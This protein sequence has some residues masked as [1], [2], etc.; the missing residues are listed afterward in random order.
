[1]RGANKILAAFI[2]C[3]SLL[4]AVMVASANQQN[5]DDKWKGLEF[6]ELGPAVMGGRIDDFAVVE[7]NP[8]IVFVGTASGGV[9]KT[10]NSGTTWQPV[11]DKQ[12]VS[13]IGAIAIAPSDPSTVWVGTG[14]PN[15]RQSSSWGDGVYKSTDTGKTWKN[16]GLTATRHIG[17]IV[18][19]PRNPDVVYVAALGHLWGPN[20][21]RGVFKSKDGGATWNNVLKINDDTGVSDIAMDPQSPETLYAAAYQRRRTPY[22]F[23]GGGP[24]SVIYKTLDGGATWTKLTKGLPYENGGDTGRI[25]LEIYRADPNIVYA[26][27][28]HEKGGI[29]RSEDKGETWKK[30]GDTNPR[31]SYYSQVRIDPKNDLR[32]WVLGAPMFYSEDGGKTFSTQRVQKIH[33]DFHAMWID[34]SDSNHMIAGSDGGIHWSYDAGR[35]WDF[36]NTIAL[37]QFY[38]MGLDDETPYHICGGLQDNGSWCGPS[39]TLTRD[40]IANEDW[41]LIHG[42][43][44]FYAAIDPV[45]PWIVYTESQDGY[46]SRRD[47]RTGQQR[48]IKPVAKVGEPHYR[49]QWNSPVAVSAHDH[50]TIYYGGNYLFKSTDRGDNW[51][52]LDGDLTTAAD[53][54]KLQIFGRTPD[55]TTL[56]RHD[57]VQEY[58]TITTLSESPLTPNVLWAGTDDGNLQVTRDAGTT[59][60]NVAPKV[61]GLAKGA[62][63]SRV[64]ASKYAEGTAFAAFDG[65]RS[66]DYGVY[67]FLTADYGDTW[68]AIRNGIPD[69]AGTVHVVREHP[70]NQ[71]LLFA[72]TEFGLW[73]S[74]DR[75]ANWAALKTNLPTVPVYDIEIQAREND[76]VLATHGRSIW[77]LDDLTPVEKMD[78]NVASSDITFFSPRPAKTWHLRNRRWSAGQKLFTAKNPPYGAILTY[79]LK[80]AVPS[81]PTKPDQLDKDKSDIDS[82][83]QNKPGS[84]DQP[85][86]DQEEKEAAVKAAAQDQ[87]KIQAKT[88]KKEKQVNSKPLPDQKIKPAETSPKEGKAKIRVLDKDGTVLREFE[89]PGAV[90]LNRT[91]WDLRWEAPAEPTEEQREAMAAGYSLGPRGPLAEPGEYTIKIKA[92]TREATQRV[93]VAEDTRINISAADRAARHDAIVQLY[94]MAKTADKDRKSIAGLKLALKTARDQ[95]KADANKPASPKIPEDIQKAAEELQK[96][97]DKVAEKYVRER[98]GLGNAGP[99]FEWKPDPLPEQVQDLLEDLDGFAAAP[100]GQQKEQLA[101]LVPLVNEGSVQVKKL[102][103]EDLPALNKKINDAGIPHI[104]PATSP[105]PAGPPGPFGHDK[106]ED[107]DR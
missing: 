99:P 36:V 6:R 67:I 54:N 13:T 85:K 71:N 45:E 55:K 43:D 11:F 95:W 46:I 62:Y 34:P 79:Y 48:S 61:S 73:I 107:S 77:V 59:W 63:V 56:S 1:M 50:N 49:F 12:N 70:R 91:N 26:L 25:G 78:A 18:I 103:E 66:D 87:P 101:Q 52:R 27:V 100:G 29:Y 19:H 41:V 20:P 72:G 22:G 57:G 51:T 2:V 47:L 24:G 60:K 23:N 44:G 82:D 94:T 93:T 104:V 10:T 102:T 64:V 98:E 17:R 84:E 30:M 37:G 69:S 8:N 97:V 7:N 21:E 5:S 42:G 32:I 35:T 33:G 40:G 38:E 90:G 31:P 86:N 53:R 16:M 14:E 83:V 3:V 80:G 39:Q 96:K 105:Q 92:G 89:G 65:H 15:N 81:E 4:I 76:L 68:K 106:A 75:G 74:S 28:Q 88:Q 58:P 9:W